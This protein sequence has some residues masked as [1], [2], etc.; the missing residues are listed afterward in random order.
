MHGIHRGRTHASG[1]THHQDT[2][3][4]IMKHLRGLWASWC[5]AL[6]Q[7]RR[8]QFEQSVFGRVEPDTIKDIDKFLQ[9]RGQLW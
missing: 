2:T 6:D 8:V 5:W 7:N 4:D 3:M 9:A 1:R